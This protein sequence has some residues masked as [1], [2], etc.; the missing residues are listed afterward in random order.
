MDD[1]ER[2]LDELREFVVFKA[3]NFQDEPEV[4]KHLETLEKEI[5]ALE[6]HEIKYLKS[7]D[8][9]VRYKA[10]GLKARTVKFQV[11]NLND[12]DFKH[13]QNNTVAFFNP[14]ELAK[15]I[16]D[17]I[18]KRYDINVEGNKWLGVYDITRMSFFK[19]EVTQKLEFLTKDAKER[20]LEFEKKNNFTQ[21]IEKEKRSKWKESSLKEARR[22]MKEAI[23]QG[24]TKEELQNILE[25]E[26]IASLMD[27]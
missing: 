1:R 21:M 2:I 7:N 19:K 12:F 18:V 13:C 23:W 5:L 17:S 14:H 27:S 22:L 3:K 10:P 24:A 6:F 25:E 16:N 4:I 8:I 26:F 11:Q 9:V 15:F 20:A